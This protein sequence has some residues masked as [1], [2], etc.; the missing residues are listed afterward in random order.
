MT[1]IRTLIAFAKYR[2]RLHAKIKLGQPAAS[3]RL[4]IFL[5]L[6]ILLFAN[7]RKVEIIVI[8]FDAFTSAA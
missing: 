5:N 3:S 2:R 7:L 4:Y 8:N 6:A 1:E